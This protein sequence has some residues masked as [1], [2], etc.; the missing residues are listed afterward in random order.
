MSTKAQDFHLIGGI[1]IMHFCDVTQGEYCIS[2]SFIRKPFA[3][4]IFSSDL[5]EL[6]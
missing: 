2:A 3:E 5:I 1:K 4:T 6:F